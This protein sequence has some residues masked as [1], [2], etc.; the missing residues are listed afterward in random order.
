MNFL[1]KKSDAE[2][3]FSEKPEKKKFQNKAKTKYGTYA[4]VISA[5]VIAAAIAVNVIFGALA[6]R[7]HLDIDISLKGYNTLTKENIKF[8]ESLPVPVT[9][10][11]CASKSGYVNNLDYYTG[12]SYGLTSSGAEYYSQ[13]ITLLEY[14]DEYSDQIT[15]EFVDFQDPAFSDIMSKYGNLGFSYGDIIVTATHKMDDGSDNVRNTIVAFDDIYKLTDPYAYYYG[16]SS[17][18]YVIGGNNLEN[19]LSAAIR[20]VSST[21]TKKVGVIQTHCSPSTITYYES[22]LE[23]NNFDVEIIEDAIL[24]EISDEYSILI[25]SAPTADFAVD[26]LDAID[27]WLYNKGERGRGLLFFASVTSPELPNLYGKLEEW[28]IVIEDGV[29]F[30]TNDYFHNANDPMTMLFTK[31]NQG[32]STSENEIMN[33]MTNGASRFAI[34]SGVPIRTIAEPKANT[35]V[36]PLI[37]SS[38]TELVVAPKDAGVNWEP[39]DDE[40]LERHNGI[41]VSMDEEW[42]NNEASRSYIVA[43]SSYSFISEAMY[44]NHGIKDNIHAAVNIANVVVGNEEVKFY[45]DTKKFESVGYTVSNKTAKTMLVVTIA[46]PLLVI[47]TGVFVFIRR[48]R[49]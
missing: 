40:V 22:V 49:R 21:D 16:S 12:Q 19:S 17:G 39:G 8:I 25:I 33:Q 7:M 34:G 5:I 29:L 32:E 44:K 42:A 20:K 43:F 46:I 28:G 4:I 10:T 41:V 6:K 24:S 45:F 26:E 37:Y 3:L 35:S 36:F 38:S 31:N 15:L 23:L 18:S 14:Y 9:I 48:R 27:E 1:K 47:A 13:T 11:V 2:I 30:D